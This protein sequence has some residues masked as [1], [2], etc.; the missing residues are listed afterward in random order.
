MLHWARS[1]FAGRQR[2]LVAILAA[3]VAGYWRRRAAD[4]SSTLVRLSRLR[5]EVFEPKI[6]RSPGQR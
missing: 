6:V 4:E 2:R 3:D 5:A 1:V